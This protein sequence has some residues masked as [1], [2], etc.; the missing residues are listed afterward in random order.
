M[1]WLCEFNQELELATELE[2]ERHY[3]SEKDVTFGYHLLPWSWLPFQNGNPHQRR[4]MSRLSHFWLCWT[5]PMTF[6]FSSSLSANQHNKHKN[7]SSPAFLTQMSKPGWFHCKW[8]KTM[9]CSGRLRMSKVCKGFGL[10]C[11]HISLH[12]YV[13]HLASFLSGQI[14]LRPGRQQTQLG[15]ATVDSHWDHLWHLWK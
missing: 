2:L 12:L 5:L 13:T 3:W 7:L 1:K 11:L 15:P 6:A 9:G 4:L 14:T 10:Q 8:R